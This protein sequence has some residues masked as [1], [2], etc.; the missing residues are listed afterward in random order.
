MHRPAVACL[1]AL[2][3]GAAGS[4]AAQA[5]DAPAPQ[6][7]PAVASPSS[8]PA[9]QRQVLED[10]HVRIEELRVRGLNRR[11]AVQPKIAGVQGYEIVP[12]E[13]GRDA[14]DRRA[15]SGRRVWRLLSF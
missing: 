5:S 15:G 8:E 9:V 12:E 14:A 4:A 1:A 7:A 2:L 13:P 10:D 6:S 3:C 11:L